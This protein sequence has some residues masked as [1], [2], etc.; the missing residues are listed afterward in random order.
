MTCTGL[1]CHLAEKNQYAEKVGQVSNKPKQ[2]H[3]CYL[4]VAGWWFWSFF[5]LLFHY[6]CFGVDILFRDFTFLT[7]ASAIRSA[8][9]QPSRVGPLSLTRQ[10][11]RKVNKKTKLLNPTPQRPKRGLANKDTLLVLSLLSRSSWLYG[12]GPH[13]DSEVHSHPTINRQREE[14]KK[15]T[16][17]QGKQVTQLHVCSPSTL[18]G[19]RRAVR[20]A[21][22][23]GGTHTNW[24]ILVHVSNKKRT[25]AH[26]NCIVP[27]YN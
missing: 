17:F 26:N 24:M 13:T 5:P 4:P 9:F 25:R 8:F 20:L 14:I 12:C 27:N 23:S 16:Q 10:N 15:R 19:R 11:Y 21:H 3:D 6:F 7:T 1:G 22:T 18:F 2:V